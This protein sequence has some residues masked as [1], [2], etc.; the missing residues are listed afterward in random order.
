MKKLYLALFF[1]ASLGLS[2]QV[3]N[4]SV[5]DCNSNAS[6]IYAAL[7]TGKPLVVASKGF[8]CSNCRSTAAALQNWASQNPN[9]QVWGAMTFN[10]S[11]NTPMCTDVSAWVGQYSWNSIFT[12]IDDSRHWY[13]FGT[14][15][16]YVYDPADSSIAYEGSSQSSALSTAAGLV[17]TVGQPEIAKKDFS[18]SAVNGTLSLFNLPEG[19]ITVQVIALTGNVVKTVNF[20]SASSIEK[21][22]LERF[23]AG[24]YLVNVQNKNGFKAVRKIYLR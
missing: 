11:G 7:A 13:K 19:P 4:K 24:I 23:T 20:G 8:D 9:V 3:S 21:V 1:G 17:T 12:F 22:A 6:C 10:Y 5:T 18:V 15:R 16:Y 14:P 2:A